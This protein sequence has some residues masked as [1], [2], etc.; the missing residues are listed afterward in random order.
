MKQRYTTLAVVCAFVGAGIGFARCRHQPQE[1]PAHAATPPAKAS[2]KPADTVR[3]VAYAATDDCPAPRPRGAGGMWHHGRVFPASTSSNLPADLSHLC[4]YEWVPDARGNAADMTKL[5]GDA[6]GPVVA[7]PVMVGSFAA[8]DPLGPLQKNFID[9]IEQPTAR[10]EVAST[11]VTLGIADS[12][13]NGITI[14]PGASQHG[15][16]VGWIAEA[17]SCL[18]GACAT[19]HMQLVL[20]HSPTGAGTLASNVAAS[21]GPDAD[22][23]GSVSELAAGIWALVDGNTRGSHLVINLSVGWEP[24]AAGTCE[25]PPKTASGAYAGLGQLALGTPTGLV[26]QALTHAVCNGALVVA[27]AGNVTGSGQAASGPTCPAR[28]ATQP[29]TCPQALIGSSSERGAPAMA[30][31]RL[32][33]A[34]GGIAGHDPVSSDPMAVRDYAAQPLLATRAG[35]F[36]VLSA[37]GFHGVVFPPGPSAGA[38]VPGRQP[39]RFTRDLSGTSVSTAVVSGIAAAVWAQ[40]PNLTGDQVMA[41]IQS[42]AVALTTP[43]DPA[44]ATTPVLAT[45]CDAPGPCPQAVRASLC[46]ALAYDG[47]SVPPGKCTVAPPDHLPMLDDAQ[48]LVGQVDPA[49][50]SDAGAPLLTGAPPSQGGSLPPVVRPEPSDPACPSCYINGSA[51][52]VYVSID[53]EYPVGDTPL[54][55]MAILYY[56]VSNVLIGYSYPL[57]EPRGGLVDGSACIDY[58]LVI[59]SGTTLATIQWIMSTGAWTAPAQIPIYYR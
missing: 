9:Q 25:D 57:A 5:P 13:P 47:T 29:V 22:V 54:T 28:Y 48:T 10:I 3:V 14:Q 45:F 20:P 35:G 37:P 53:P 55:S 38:A 40:H 15:Y 23:Y 12:S 34:V 58:G 7:D 30:P 24:S 50:V 8:T 33:Y 21:T 52:Y 49:N 17:M 6:L 59:P 2:W 44:G 31:S 56:N 26:L 1:S 43:P 41:R 36:P 19:P 11:S 42:S 51:A 27:A 39:T 4:F 32:V 16:N 46:R 18:G